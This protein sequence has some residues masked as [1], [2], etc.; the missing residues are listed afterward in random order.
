MNRDWCGWFWLLCSIFD[1]N[2]VRALTQTSRK[3]WENRGHEIFWAKFFVKKKGASQEN[4]K[5]E[6]LKIVHFLL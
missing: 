1:A 4:T 5:I 3:R 6:F 2:P